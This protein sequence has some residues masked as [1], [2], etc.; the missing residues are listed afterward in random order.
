MGFRHVAPA[1]VIDVLLCFS[2]HACNGARILGVI[3]DD[4]TTEFYQKNDQKHD[5]GSLST[6]ALG[7]AKM[8]NKFEKKEIR[9]ELNSR[10]TEALASVSRRVNRKKRGEKEPGFNL[11][12]LPPKTHPPVHN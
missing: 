6:N 12:Y 10:K 9:N 3:H 8:R 7:E 11:D 5:A 4:P 1:T 2:Y